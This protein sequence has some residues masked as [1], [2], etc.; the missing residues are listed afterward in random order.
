MYR[1]AETITEQ[2]AE[3]EAALET[4]LFQ[5]CGKL[6][7]QRYGWTPPLGR[8]GKTLSHTAG[9]CTMLCGK[10]QEKIIP[11]AAIK[12]ALENKLFE[13]REEEGRPVGRKERQSLKD[14][15][16]FTMLPQALP[17]SSVE[18]GYYNQ[19][20]K[21]VYIN[22]ASAKKAEDFLTLLR[23]SIGSLKVVPL[24]TH[25]PIT[26]VL[27]DWL[28]NGE[29]PEPF[30]LGEMCELRASK[31][32][33]VIRFRKQDLSADEV[34]QH[35]DTGMHVRQLSLEWKE[36]IQF[37]IDDELGIKSVKFSDELVEKAGDA[38]PDSEAAMFDNEFAIMTAE[39]S[40]FTRDLLTAFGGEAEIF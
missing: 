18:F 27:T 2:D 8:S 33:R 19:R 4:K 16:I 32:E 38:D 28:R 14:E 24:A 36:S 40:A 29:A 1:L 12:E 26:P 11:G 34:R 31:D 3:L 37:V 17:K 39:L 13:I 30:T 9:D 7:L 21:L 25:N 35:L 22:V 10:R 23:E 6:D 5:P 15:L 20:D